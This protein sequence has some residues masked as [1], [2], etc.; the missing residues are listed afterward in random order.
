MVRHTSALAYDLA[1]NRIAPRM[2]DLL[3]YIT[4]INGC[5]CDEYERKT[6]ESH[7]SVSPLFTRLAE[8]GHIRDSGIMRPTRSGRLAIVWEIHPWD[9]SL[10]APPKKL[11]RAQLYK[12]AI[13][14]AKRV[15]HTNDWAE[16]D[17]ILEELEGRS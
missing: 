11:T 2:R 13:E 5:T 12:R 16:F 6:G 15:R 10:F 8:L 4:L 7:Q 14:A 9:G 17:S 1:K 3:N